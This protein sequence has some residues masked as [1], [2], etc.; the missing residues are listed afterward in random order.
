ME[1]LSRGMKLEALKNNDTCNGMGIILI[2]KIS[3]SGKYLNKMVKNCQKWPG[4]E[5]LEK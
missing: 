2:L 1:I 3:L 5:N 4:L